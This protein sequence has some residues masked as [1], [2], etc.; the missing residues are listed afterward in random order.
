MEEYIPSTHIIFE[1]VIILFFGFF[2]DDLMEFYLLKKG[3]KLVR[4]IAANNEIEAQS[5]YYLTL[6]VL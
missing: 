4:I 2:A 3:Y 1:C 6:D 5:K